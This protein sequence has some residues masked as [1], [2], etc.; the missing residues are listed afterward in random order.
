VKSALRRLVGKIEVHGEE[1]PGRKR[2]GAVL[3]L[4]GSVEAA[5]QL[6]SEKVKG[7]NSPGGILALV[8][9]TDPVRVM[10]L[11]GRPYARSDRV[12]GQQRVFA[13]A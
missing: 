13:S 7:G 2:P 1:V 8:T 10:S 6:A 3:V 5:L 11:E 4:R 9:F 12:E